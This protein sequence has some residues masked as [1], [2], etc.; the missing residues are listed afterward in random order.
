LKPSAKTS[1]QQV[2]QFVWADIVDTKKHSQLTSL[3]ADAE[4]TGLSVLDNLN[5]RS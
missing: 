4:A 5:G 1:G 2:N 3:P